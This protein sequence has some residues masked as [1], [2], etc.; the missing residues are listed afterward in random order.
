MDKNKTSAT[1]KHFL[2][3]NDVFHIRSGSLGNFE[4]KGATL[5]DTTIINYNLRFFFIEA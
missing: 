1:T 3:S 2:I 5:L 4:A